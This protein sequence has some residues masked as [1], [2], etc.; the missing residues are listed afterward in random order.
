MKVVALP[1]DGSAYSD[2]SFVKDVT[3]GLLLPANRKRLNEIGLVKSAEWSMAHAYRVRCL[4]VVSDI[5]LYVVNEVL[6]FEFASVDLI[7]M[8]AM[9]GW[10]H[11]R[12]Q[13]TAQEKRNVDLIASNAFLRKS[14]AKLAS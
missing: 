14:N 3:K 8:Q 4:Y 2:P 6:F 7:C 1:V 12:S 9:M 11:L 13:I 10:T 5:D